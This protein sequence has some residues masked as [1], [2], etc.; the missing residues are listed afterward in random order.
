[1]TEYRTN[2]PGQRVPFL[3]ERTGLLTR[4]WYQF[5]ATLFNATELGTGGDGDKGDIT[6]SGGGSVWTIDNGAVDTAKLGGDITPAGKTLLNDS[7][8][9]EQ[10]ATLGLGTLATM[11]DGDFVYRSG[12]TITGW[13]NVNEY[14]VG[15]S[16]ITLNLTGQATDGAMVVTVDDTCSAYYSSVINDVLRSAVG[17]HGTDDVF[18]VRLYDIE[19]LNEEIGL[20]AAYDGAVSLYYD[21]TVRLETLSLGVSVSG[22][23]F[24]TGSSIFDI[25]G[26]SDALRVTQSGTGNVVVFEDSAN[27]DSSPWIIDASGVQIHGHTAAV[28]CE[29]TQAASQVTPARQIMATT[30]AGSTSMQAVY[31]TSSAAAC[32]AMTMARSRGSLASHTVVSV[33]DRLGAIAFEGSDGTEFKRA[34]LII[35][36]CDATPS[37]GV[38]PGRVLIR[39][40]DSGGTLRTRAT[41]D[42]A[43]TLVLASTYSG[44]IRFPSTQI[45]VADANTLDD[46]EEG[47]FTPTVV[48]TSTAGSGTYSTQVGRYT[49]VGNLVAF[50]VTLEWSAHTGTGDIRISGLPFTSANVTGMYPALSVWA[51]SLTFSGQ[52]AAR[53]N[54]G[55][56][57]FDLQSIATGAAAAAVAIDTAAAVTLS[58]IYEAQ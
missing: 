5:F 24:V 42:S 16:S 21:D 57:T 18:T 48:G 13:L 2:I 50:T 17:Y 22:G 29:A 35:G 36:E 37:T 51:D 45:A 32:P 33:G 15:K 28:V 40:T 58:G 43:G 31:T 4:E 49:K 20:T 41:L 54:A 7:D 23:I 25:S 53:I 12:D 1:M 3:D 34:A 8:A 44:G 39:T 46:Y 19:G 10:R 9:A 55:A 6:V 26:S 11:N 38:V 52:L 27:P 30:E 56:T 47:T 14:L